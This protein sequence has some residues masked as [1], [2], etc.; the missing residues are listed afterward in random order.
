MNRRNKEGR[1]Q[2]TD[3][4][5]KKEEKKEKKRKRKSRRTK[6]FI[7]RAFSCS[8]S[9]GSSLLL[10]SDTRFDSAVSSCGTP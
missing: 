4:E 7:R 10:H 2:Q 9:S 8:A 5:R 6:P 1:K 3:E